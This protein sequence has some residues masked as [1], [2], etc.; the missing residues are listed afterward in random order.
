MRY[1]FWEI[2]LHLKTSPTAAAKA[3]VGDK[4]TQSGPAT[5]TGTYNYIPK[6]DV[7]SQPGQASWVL[8]DEL[9]HGPGPLP[10]FLEGSGDIGGLRTGFCKCD[11]QLADLL[12]INPS[13]L[14]ATSSSGRL[15]A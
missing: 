5:A 13:S 11:C 6:A 10:S 7:G 1:G 15:W 9:D 2:A 14:N 8:V 3:T 4:N 12:Q